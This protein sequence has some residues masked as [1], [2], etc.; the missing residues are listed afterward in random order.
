MHDFSQACRVKKLATYNFNKYLITPDEFVED[1]YPHDEIMKQVDEL[2]TS[3]RDQMD[4]I[5]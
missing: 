4:F 1:F 5:E 3:Q 2:F